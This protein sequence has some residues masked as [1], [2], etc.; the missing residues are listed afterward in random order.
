ME[1]LIEILE[2]VKPDVDYAT[3][4]ALIDDGIIESLELMQLISELENE[5]DIEIEMENLIPENFN[6][7]EAIMA[8]VESLQ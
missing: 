2:E 8:L 1:R 6:S 3:E 4:K 5:Y 7:A